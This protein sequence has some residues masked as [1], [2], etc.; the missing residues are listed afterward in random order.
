MK[1]YFDV[2]TS[3]LYCGLTD[4]NKN[5]LTVKAK[6][7]VTFKKNKIAI[8]KS[9]WYSEIIDTYVDQLCSQLKI[10]KVIS[11]PGCFEIPLAIQKIIEDYDIVIA[12]G[13]IVKGDTYHFEVIS[14]TITDA[15]MNIQLKYNKCIVN[16]ILNCYTMDHVIERFSNPCSIVDTVKYIIN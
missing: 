11:V 10:E 6:K 5:Y 12:V 2:E 7:H 14:H 13:A 1:S 8:V 15:L 3:I 9:M 4:V 16:N